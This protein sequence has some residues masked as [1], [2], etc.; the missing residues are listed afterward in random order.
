MLTLCGRRRYT[1]LCRSVNTLNHMMEKQSIQLVQKIDKELPS[2]VQTHIRFKHNYDE[3]VHNELIKHGITD[4]QDQQR[5]TDH[6]VKHVQVIID[7]HKMGD[8]MFTILCVAIFLSFLFC[9][10]NA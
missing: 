2:I 4:A 7:D 9:V 6:I 1:I 3:Y 8:K 10:Y 5:V